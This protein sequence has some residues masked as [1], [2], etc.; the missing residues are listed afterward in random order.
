[1]KRYRSDSNG[2]ADIGA[3]GRNG[4]RV[5]SNG[6]VDEPDGNKADFSESLLASE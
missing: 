6:F 3:G 2:D 4:G 1:M 5:K